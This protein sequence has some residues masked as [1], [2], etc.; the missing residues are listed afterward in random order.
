MEGASHG[1]QVTL[2]DGRTIPAALTTFAATY[3]A[4]DSPLMVMALPAI[5]RR[6][7]RHQSDPDLDL[8]IR[9]VRPS[10]R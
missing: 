5:W 3:G 6:Q 9:S 10:K 2:P 7:A 4:D 8:L 1:G